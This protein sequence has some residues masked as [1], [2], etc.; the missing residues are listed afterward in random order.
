MFR[1][2]LVLWTVITLFGAS[3][4]L[5]SMAHD[6]P[7][8]TAVNAFVKLEPHQADL[9]IRVPLD[10][11]HSVQFPMNGNLYDLS[12]AGPGT[13]MALRGIAQGI[14]IR[15]TGTRLVP[16]AAT[17]R[18]DLPSDRS[19][20][21]YD[22]AA[23][24][25]AEPI[26][27]HTG[28][29]FDQGYL[30]AHF[31][32]PIRSASSVFTIQTTL[33]GDLKDLVKLTVRFEP[34]GGSSRAF[35]ITSNSGQVPLDPTWLQASRGFVVLGVEHIFERDRSFAFSA[36]PDHSVSQDSRADPRDYRVYA[37]AFGDAAGVG[38]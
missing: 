25:V 13:E 11:L 3:F 20:E 10:L 4:S 31:I 24:H 35:I 12:A 29:Y 2:R 38:F 36:V 14:D 8:N 16:T 17:G 23:A 19:F 27:P 7:L 18:F 28:I 33:A 26:D 21:D 15:E 1:H 37:G 30:D 5:P 34:L 22:R 6:V 32:Y 9:V